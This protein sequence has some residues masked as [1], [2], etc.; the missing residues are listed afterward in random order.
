MKRIL[1]SSLF[2]VAALVA[3]GQVTMKHVADCNSCLCSRPQMKQD[4]P[5]IVRNLTPILRGQVQ[6]DFARAEYARLQ[7]SW[8]DQAQ[9]SYRQNSVE[10]TL[11]NAA[12]MGLLELFKKK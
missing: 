2:A 7:T 5:Q 1:F 4:A 10:N 12:A 9:I 6:Q 3:H 11:F 8:F